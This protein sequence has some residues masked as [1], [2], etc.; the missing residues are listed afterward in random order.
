[1]IFID[2]FL[3]CIFTCF[4]MLLVYNIVCYNIYVINI[5]ICHFCHLSL[6]TEDWKL[7]CH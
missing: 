7:D 2:L 1:M 3:M 4:E 6:V 5:H